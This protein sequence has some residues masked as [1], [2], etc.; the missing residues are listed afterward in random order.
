MHDANGQVSFWQRTCW[1]AIRAKARREPLAAKNVSSLGLEVFLPKLKVE[2]DPDYEARENGKPLFSGYFFARFCLEIS[3]ASVECSH[4][5]L[6]VVKSGRYPIPV[7][8]QIIQEIQKRVQADGLIRIHRKEL[9]PGDRVSIQSGP[10]EGMMAR[11]ERELDD[12]KRVS[13]LLETLSYAR[14]QMD[15]RWVQ[16]E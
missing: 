6:Q 13:I 12:R 2:G 10:F 1:F 15:K 8:D 3:L 4:G 9:K 14:V 7:D 5:V 16:A 11:V